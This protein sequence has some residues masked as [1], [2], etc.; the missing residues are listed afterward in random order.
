MHTAS[1]FAPLFA[2]L[3][4]GRG[5][6]LWPVAALILGILAV[7]AVVYLYVREAG[8]IP[9]GAR[10]AMAAVRVAIVAAVA[11]LLIRPVLVSDESTEKLRPVVVLVDVSQSMDAVDPRPGND[12][13]ARAAIAFGLLPIGGLPAENVS[14][15]V[16]RDQLLPAEKAKRVEIARATLTNPRFDILNR[17]KAVGPLEVYTFGDR[18][19]GRDAGSDGWLRGLEAKEPRTALAAAGFELLNRDDTDAPAALVVVTDGRE[20]GGPKSLDDL[21][22]ECYRRNI[23]VYVYGVGATTV[24]QLQAAFGGATAAAA[25]AG[26]PGVSRAGADVDVP[27]TLFVDD[28]A[29]IPVRYTVKGVPAGTAEIV[30]RYGDREVATKKESFSLAPEEVRAGRTFATVVKFVPTK[31]DAESKKQEYSATVTITSGAEALSSTVSR[32][33]QVVNRKLK[34]LVVDGLPRYDFKFLQRALLRDRRVDAKFYLTEG[35]KA[36]MRSGPPWMVDFSKEVDGVLN[37]DKDE[38]RKTLFDFDLLILGDVPG[39][40]FTRPHQEVIKEFVTEGGGLIHVAGRWHGPAEWAT[41]KG[42]AETSP[43]A[44]VL[45]VEVEPVRFPVQAL[46][47]PVGFVPVLAPASARTQIVT[48]ED[49]VVENADLWGKPGPPPALQDPKQLKPFYWHYPVVRTKPAADVFLSHP[50]ARTPAPEDKPM[51]LL[52]G[53][54]FGK[55]Y[56]LFVGFDDTW[57]WRF[58]TQEKYFGRFWT[59]AVYTAGI[60]RIVGTKQTQVSSNTPAPTV[61]TAGEVY[62]RAFNADYQPLGSDEVEGTLERLDAGPDDKD[63]SVPVTFRKV[64]GVA[65][66]Y[67]ATL[68]YNRAGQF[69][70]TVDPKNKSLAVLNFPVTYPDTHE[71][72]PGP[73]DEPALRKLTR[74]SRGADAD[75]GFYREE[76]LHRLPAEVKPQAVPQ[77]ARAETLLWNEWA[78]IALIV[79]LTVEWVLR[80]FNGLS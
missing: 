28:T 51:P 36:A 64:P 61:G 5:G 42:A 78:M 16:P 27:N 2:G 15:L 65:G 33:A 71:L 62:L 14:S 52:A 25:P 7:A 29:A 35:D 53:H 11:F 48:L 10:V 38:F 9:V 34:V 18:R 56:V 58:N 40:Y 80:K 21:A 73:M 44:D 77:T 66:E 8:R 70:L 79:L 59:Q 1:A 57:R 24:G 43:I 22:R 67:V 6:A 3:D 31:D 23:P 39:K 12:D 32:P 37:M 30:V 49:D 72:A 46:D 20:N 63:R 17:L 55:G 69:R 26:T 68:A 54:T 60:P 41:A 75:A 74:D 13:Q 47:N 4:F 19:T 50:T 76:T 45:P